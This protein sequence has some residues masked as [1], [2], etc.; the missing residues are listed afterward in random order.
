[1]WI[2]LKEGML[3]I[4]DKAT[5]PNHLVVRARRAG[6]LET[7]FPKA[8]VEEGGGTDYRFR[9]EVPREE[10]AEVIAWHVLTLDYPNFKGAVEDGPRHHAY[11]D[12][13]AVMRSYQTSTKA[14]EGRGRRCPSK[15]NS[16]AHSTNFSGN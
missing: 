1:M 8:I 16:K 13:W 9:A 12:V 7:F 6:E 4:V 11:S 5:R 14:A 10:V 3:S 15:S 2:F